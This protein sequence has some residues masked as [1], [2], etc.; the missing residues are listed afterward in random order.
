MSAVEKAASVLHN[1]SDLYLRQ[2]E[3][4]AQALADAGLLAD[5]TAR[6]CGCGD[7]ESALHV[8]GCYADTKGQ[9]D[10]PSDHTA[11]PGGGR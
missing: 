5:S 9:C 6:C 11:Q 10:D 8:H 7:C 1:E 2:A 4:L 3:R